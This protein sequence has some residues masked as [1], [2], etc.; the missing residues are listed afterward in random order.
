LRLGQ[1]P[2]A[3]DYAFKV[4][5]RSR[6]LFRCKTI[7]HAVAAGRSQVLLAAAA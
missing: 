3:F 5:E 4:Y 2:F 6:F 7:Q 1:T